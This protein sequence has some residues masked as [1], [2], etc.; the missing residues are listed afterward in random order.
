MELALDLLH[1]RDRG[2]KSERM[3]APLDGG[4][5]MSYFLH[6]P[7]SAP[8]KVLFIMGLATEHRSWDGHATYLAARGGYQCCNFDNYGIGHSSSARLPYLSTSTLARKALAL[9]R[10]LGWQDELHI[11]GISMGG[12]VAQELA[13]LMG[14][15]HVPSLTLI[16]T[17]RGGL[18]AIPVI[19]GSL[20][21]LRSLFAPDALS[22]VRLM[23]KMVYHPSTLGDEKRRSMLEAMHVERAKL[24]ARPTLVS[25][26]GQVMGTLT[27]NVSLQRLQR[28]R[29]SRTRVLV[30]VGDND[31]MVRLSNSPA[32]ARLVDARFVRFD[33]C[34]HAVVRERVADLA[35]EIVKEI[36]ASSPP[37]QECAVDGQEML[38]AAPV[39]QRVDSL[40]VMRQ[41][42]WQRAHEAL[43]LCCQHG[44]DCHVWIAL[45]AAQLALPLA[46]ATKLAAALLP[47]TLLA[48]LPPLRSLLVVAVLLRGQ[49][50]AVKCVVKGVMAWARSRSTEKRSEHRLH[51]P[52]RA[53]LTCL[54]LTA[55]LCRSSHLRS[56]LRWLFQRR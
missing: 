46:L 41:R 10:H 22:R 51:F 55:A 42:Y 36:D 32:L 20:L 6:G 17:H 44:P 4:E 35:L 29:Y 54:L 52:S 18:T 34:G 9:V 15:E 53:A 28:L 16:A 3:F 21:F 11:V 39:L 47:S 13:L 14:P 38:V 25:V 23:M 27:H 7:D 40:A 49:A 8:R 37:L 50:S 56:L 1:L 2:L 33:A 24:G 12:M 45:R 30:V 5:K 26:I 19:T 43:Q 48:R 31:N